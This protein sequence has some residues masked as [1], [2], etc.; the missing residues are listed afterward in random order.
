MGSTLLV[1][2]VFL[3]AGGPDLQ[4]Q[5]VQVS[6]EFRKVGQWKP[7]VGQEWAVVLIQGLQV[8][9]FNKSLVE[10]APLREW[11]KP[12]SMLVKRLAR[13][14]DVYS[15][16]YGQTVTVTDIADLPG[17]REGIGRLRALG[18]RKVVLIGHSAGGLVARRLVEDCPDL[19]VTKVIQ[20]C[21][22]NGGSSWA[23][24]KALPARQKVFLQSLTKEERRQAL[25]ERQEVVIPEEVEFVCLVGTLGWG[26][27]GVV[28]RES[29]WSPDL[30]EQGI[31]AVPLA[32]DHW[33][34]VR[35]ASEIDQI[36]QLVRKPHRRW[37]P[38]EVAAMR[39]RLYGG[40][41][42]GVFSQ[43]TEK[44]ETKKK[45]P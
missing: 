19:G 39:K 3:V 5:F 44:K 26:G 37:T 31:P 20:V 24:L 13:E 25:R 23:K 9:P 35:S 15:F 2:C 11:Q 41:V 43:P 34:A 40:G 42:L 18:Y 6:P 4:T 14:G 29:Q 27:D 10:K 21:C 32:T 17:L 36:A 22:P 45:L 7:S 8:R 28:S 1:A 33:S 12:S 16:A 30:Q 38:A